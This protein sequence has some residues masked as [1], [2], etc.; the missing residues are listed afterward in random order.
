[1]DHQLG[2]LRD[3]L[4]ETGVGR[5][6][7]LWFC[8]DN[9][10]EGRT[11][12]S[13]VE[14]SD[15]TYLALVGAGPGST[16]PF[17]GR[18]RD[19]FEGGIRVPGLLEWPAKIEPG[20]VTDAVVCT[21]DFLPTMVDL[22]DLPMPGSRVL[23]GVSIKSVLDGCGGNRCRPIA[24]ES[25]G[26]FA[27]VDNRFKIVHVPKNVDKFNRHTKPAPT[28]PSTFML[29]DLLDDP[30]EKHNIAKEYPEIVDRLARQVYVWRESYQKSLQGQD[31]RS[32]TP[33]LR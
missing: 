13:T 7:R 10:P 6:T 18:K 17:H 25:R 12:S 23:D 16:G 24:F 8:S 15:S 3:V 27:L 31:Y 2:R 30:G 9:G 14:S 19:L 21:S 1:M 5:R 33:P 28:A 29:F 4:D 20:R 32:S 22:F 26:M 11:V